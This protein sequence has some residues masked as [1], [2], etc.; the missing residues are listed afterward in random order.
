[1][2]DVHDWACIEEGKV[3]MVVRWDGVTSWP[4]ADDYLMV[5]LTDH[6]GVGIG[7]D[8]QDG[9]FI[10]NRPEPEPDEE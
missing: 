7:W 5:D 6:P 4:P 8:Y 3:R 10:D 1:M 9:Q 2:S